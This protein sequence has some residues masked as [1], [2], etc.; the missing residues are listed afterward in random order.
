MDQKTNVIFGTW[1]RLLYCLNRYW[2]EHML[3]LLMVENFNQPYLDFLSHYDDGVD[4]SSYD[5]SQDGLSPTFDDLNK[6]KLA[7]RHR[8]IAEKYRKGLYNLLNQHVLKLLDNLYDL[9]DTYTEKWFSSARSCLEE[10]AGQKRDKHPYINLSNA[11]DT[12]FQHVNVLV[13]SGPLVPSLVKCL[14]YRLDKMIDCDKVY[15]SLEVGKLQCF[16]WIK[17]R[18]SGP[19]FQFCVVG[20]GWEECE[21]AETMNWPFVKI[22]L[23]PNSN[24]RFPGLTSR[25]LQRYITVVYE[26]LDKEDKEA[27]SHLE[28]YENIA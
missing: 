14:L 13:T 16:S 7:Y 8:A 2:M 22:D 9:T 10:C 27:V 19:D 24:H 23:L 17:E 21:A 15:S 26:K 6:R 3:R 5:Y 25:D 4:L 12:T 1:M 11:R 20:D 28:A 18:F